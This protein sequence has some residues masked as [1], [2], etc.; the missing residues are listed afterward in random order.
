MKVFTEKGLIDS[1][2]VD[3]GNFAPRSRALALVI[4]TQV[5]TEPGFIVFAKGKHFC[6]ATFDM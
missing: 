2:N 4:G 6:A 5:D 3:Y 1:T